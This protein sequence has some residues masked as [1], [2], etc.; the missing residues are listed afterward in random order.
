MKIRNIRPSSVRGIPRAWGDIPVRD[1]G[2]IIL[3]GNGTGKSS[4]VDAVEIVIHGASTLFA[5]NRWGVNW[6]RAAPHVFGGESQVTCTLANG[7]DDQFEVALGAPVPEEV[8]EWVGVAKES[9]FVLRRHML[10]NFIVARPADRY[11]SLAMFLDLSAYSQIERQ[12]HAIADSIRLSIGEQ[13]AATESA[14]ERLRAAFR[15]EANES[16]DFAQLVH[17]SIGTGVRLGLA[18]AGEELEI[19]ALAARARAALL[20]EKVSAD[21]ERLAGLKQVAN[22]LPLPSA[23]NVTIRD[24][25]RACEAFESLEHEEIQLH[26]VAVIN[27]SLKLLSDFEIE[28]CPVCDT[29]IDRNQLADLL[30]HKLKA[31]EELIQAKE[32]LDSASRA[33]R[34][35]AREMSS[36]YKHFVAGSGDLANRDQWKGY[37]H[38]SETLAEIC[39]QTQN[40]LTSATVSRMQLSID[41]LLNSHESILNE[42]DGLIGELGGTE[43]WNALRNLSNQA[44]LC[45][46]ESEVIHN[47]ATVSRSLLKQHLIAA[48][49]ANHSSEARKQ[50][51]SQT[52]NEITSTANEFY[53]VIHPGEGIATSRLAVWE[54]RDASIKLF[55]EFNG[56]EE[57]P[58][59]HFSESHLDTLGLCYFLAVR[60][61]QADARPNFKLLVL[62]DVLHS[63][64]SDHRRRVVELLRDNFSDHQ[65]IITTHDHVFFRHLREI[66]GR[67]DIQQLKLNGWSL[68]RGPLLGDS[69]TDLD[70]IAVRE[71]REQKSAEELAGAAG[72]FMEGLLKRLT[73]RLQVSIRARFDTKHVLGDLWQPLESALKS[74]VSFKAAHGELIREISGSVWLRNEIGAH[75]NEEAAPPTDVEV[76]KFA[77]L[78]AGLF[79]A[80]F[81]TDCKAYIA[82][83]DN[84]DWACNCQSL[85]YARR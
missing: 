33:L 60:K 6:E 31:S 47:A 15:L 62:D 20:D 25:L 9:S 83:Q 35:S 30:R 46:S 78:L 43:R 66:F 12:L 40:E 1:R 75:D 54:A 68:D 29:A 77:E 82:R 14:N 45:I 17:R 63:V 64:D 59:L 13:Q 85:Y 36:D 7:N 81:C 41:G 3:G 56:A 70:R 71:V 44:D 18:E 57:N 22:R 79:E 38:V 5:D 76:R 55:C 61:K 49:I 73:E 32:S 27:A 8:A 39:E 28:A 11:Q 26:L 52:L 34:N 51:V 16:I 74:C 69:A 53:E 58:L 21:L 4:I 19:E 84:R 10:L 2:V 37:R 24:V 48:S 23:L 42:L 67:A 80:T 65:L 72:R 50:A